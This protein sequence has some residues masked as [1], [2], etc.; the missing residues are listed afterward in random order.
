MTRLL[1]PVL[2]A[3]L[4]LGACSGGETAPAR[5]GGLTSS[6]HMVVASPRG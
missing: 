6:V 4:F 5:E 1:F 2:A 3:S